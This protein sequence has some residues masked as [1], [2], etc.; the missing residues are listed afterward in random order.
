MRRGSIVFLTVALG[1]FAA[2]THARAGITWTYDTLPSTSTIASDNGHSSID[3]TL[4]PTIT[5][6]GS[7]DIVMANLNAN[8]STNDAHPDALSHGNYTLVLHLTDTASGDSTNLAFTGTIT[9]NV[10]AHSTTTH[11]VF[12]APT[13]EMAMLGKYTYLVSLTSYVGPGPVGSIP[14]SIGA[15]VAIEPGC[16]HA[17][18]EPTGLALAGLGLGCL[19]LVRWRRR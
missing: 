8:S 7:S 14:G 13:T 5:A 3:L 18:A 15:H 4:Q 2:S 19:G 17:A 10:A 11:N 12:H 1:V 9:G 16:Q 6:V